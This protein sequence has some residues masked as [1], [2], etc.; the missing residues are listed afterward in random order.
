MAIAL[1][2]AEGGDVELLPLDVDGIARIDGELLG[3]VRIERADLRPDRCEPRDID[4]GISQQLE[5]A[6][7]ASVAID[8]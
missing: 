1:V 5:G 6:P 3:D 8:G 4:I 2:L 7:L